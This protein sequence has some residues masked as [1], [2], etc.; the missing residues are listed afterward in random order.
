[1][2]SLSQ[3]FA[4][5]QRIAWRLIENEAVLIDRGE[6]EVLR[7]NPIATGIWNAID[8]QR[9]LSEVIDHLHGQ[10]DVDRRR[11][12]RDVLKFMKKLVRRELVIQPDL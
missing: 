7:L 12:E 11:L 4:R 2:V 10:F 9:A 8:G 6:K 3:R 5:D 1:M